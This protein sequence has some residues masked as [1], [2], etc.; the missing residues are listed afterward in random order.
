MTAKTPVPQTGLRQAMLASA[1]VYF[2]LG[3]AGAT[4][5]VMVL[6]GGHV[7]A[8]YVT[9][10]MTRLGVALA[11]GIVW[12]NA[13]PLLAVIGVFMAIT[14]AAAWLGSRV[15]ARRGAVLL[16][17]CAA[18]LAIAG[19]VATQAFSLAFVLLIAGAMG[20]LNQVRS[21]EAGVTFITGTVVKTGRALAGGDIVGT[22]VG[23]LRVLSFCGGVIVAARVDERLAPYTLALLAAAAAL[24]AICEWSSVRSAGRPLMSCR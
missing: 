8:I 20:T 19:V 7:F 2:L 18:L 11:Q 9:G 6:H 14:T 21:D 3:L 10:D 4:D 23:A 15:G 24:G 17:V 13:A 1:K 16:A 12:P 22:V 5:A